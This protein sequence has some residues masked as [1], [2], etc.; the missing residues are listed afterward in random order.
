MLI[1]ADCGH[2]LPSSLET[3]GFQS[4]QL[5]S[6]ALL[7]AIAGVATAL[8]FLSDAVTLDR[9]SLSQPADLERR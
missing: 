2:P 3:G 8:S 1:C 7:L 4:S 5:S 6:V 9:Y